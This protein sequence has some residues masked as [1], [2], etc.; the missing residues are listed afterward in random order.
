MM[1]Q[2]MVLGLVLT[3]GACAVEHKT[4]VVPAPTAVATVDDPCT[5]YGFT[6]STA[7]YVSCQARLAEQRR[8]GRVAVTY[9]DARITADA[10][11]ACSSYGIPRGTAQYNRCVQDEF[12]ARR[13][14]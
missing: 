7:D 3:A 8:A 5:R 13:P 14:G 4:V 12:A 11:V 6:A 10:Q 9:G 2:L 1:K